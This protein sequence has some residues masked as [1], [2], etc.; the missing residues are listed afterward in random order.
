MDALL[1]LPC[2]HVVHLLKGTSRWSIETNTTPI[3]F[4]GYA[5][6]LNVRLGER[7][8]I[9]VLAGVA[10]NAD[11]SPFIVDVIKPRNSG[12]DWTVRQAYVV[13]IDYYLDPTAASGW[14][15][16]QFN[17]VFEN[18]VERGGERARF[19]THTPLVRAGYK[20]YPLRENWLYLSPWAGI[21]T[22]Y[23]WGAD[24]RAAGGKQWRTSGFAYFGSLN[25]GVTL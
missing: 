22:E 10:G 23:Q 2:W 13:A 4:G 7:R 16:G 1:Q 9:G 6:A 12:L 25:V 21:G 11:F 20:W 5:A 24:S 17:F 15:V 18:E 14:Y 8:R 19:T 3:I